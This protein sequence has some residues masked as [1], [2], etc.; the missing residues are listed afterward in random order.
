M[1]IDNTNYSLG[2]GNEKKEE[3]GFSYMDCKK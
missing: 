3:V 2:K 1:K